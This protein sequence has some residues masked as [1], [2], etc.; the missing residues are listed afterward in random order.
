MLTAPR[1]GAEDTDR[2]TK[3]AKMA[4]RASRNSGDSSGREKL[5]CVKGS[6]QADDPRF[7][8]TARTHRSIDDA[9]QLV[10]EVLPAG[11]QLVELCR[12]AVDLP[13]I[14]GDWYASAHD[15]AVPDGE[16]IEANR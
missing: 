9:W 2:D 16:H 1:R 4:P 7:Y 14:R 6:Y 10:E 8:D 13:G 11:W 12:M 15:P 5:V 3:P